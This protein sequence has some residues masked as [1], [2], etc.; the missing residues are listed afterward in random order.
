MK[1]YSNG[2]GNIFAQT[3]LVAADLA[4]QKV[5]VVFKD[6][7]AAN[8]KEFKA[9]NVTGKF[10]MLELESGEL[11]FESGAIA[12]HFA[13]Q[14]AGLYGQTPFE[15]A[16]CDEWISFTQSNLWPALM[17]VARSVLGHTV[18]PQAEFTAAVAKLKSLAKVLNSYLADKH[19]LV[20]ESLS[21]A[22]VIASC[23]LLV[24]FQTVFDAGFRKGMP[25]VSAW[26]ERCMG[27]PSF[28][29][30]LGYVKMTD[31]AWKAWDPTAKVE[32][33]AAPKE[34]KTADDDMDL[35]GDDDEEDVAAAEAAKAA[36]KGAKKPKKVVIA[37]SLVLFEVK[38]LDDTTDLDEMAKRILAINDDGI[39]W[40]T[41][42]K[43]EPVAFGI[44]KLI[45]GVTVEDEKVSVDGLVDKIEAFED[46]VQSVEIVAFNKI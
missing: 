6:A 32:A 45:I 5:E 24:A 7:A 30:C 25:H 17:P 11:I 27:L 4:G 28:V 26:F 20:G 3:A 31:K 36:A 33:P 34:E 35:F 44:F 16:K 8:E 13:R 19:F 2:P 22:D 15:T 21:V 41:Q 43:K 40:K 23:A 18:V 46:M 10:P 1:L 42:Y 14:G 38:P 29:R 9:K 39:Y 12:Q 37:Q